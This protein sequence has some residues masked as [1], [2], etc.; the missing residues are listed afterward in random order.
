[1]IL[2]LKVIVF[3]VISV[4]LAFLTRKSLSSFRRHGFYRFLA[5]EMIL[6]LFLM[7]VGYWLKNPGS[8]YQ[9]ISWLLLFISLYPVIDGFRLL[10]SAGHQNKARADEGLLEFEKT[11]HLVTSG[12][13]R[14]IRHPLYASLLY[15]AWGIFF[16]H[17][18]PAGFVLALA[19]SLFLTLTAKAEEAENIS[20]WGD[21]YRQ[22][23]SR[24]KMFFPYIY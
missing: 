22:F 16:K 14:Y 8:G 24:T 20:F 5:W 17:P 23:M 4:Y 12:I 10:R 9:V 1:M 19:A 21:T 18:S 3:I 7:N 13:Y 6:I 2:S 11:D 15:L